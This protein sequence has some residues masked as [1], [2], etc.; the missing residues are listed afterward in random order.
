MQYVFGVDVDDGLD[1]LAHIVL[2]V[3][4]WHLCAPLQSLFQILTRQPVTPSEQYSMKM[5]W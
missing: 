4:F 3:L 1:Y 2:D 5:C